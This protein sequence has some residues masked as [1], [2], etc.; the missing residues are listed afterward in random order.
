[1][2]LY[3]YN[4]LSFWGYFMKSQTQTEKSQHGSVRSYTIGFLLS[5]ILTFAAY[6]PVVIHQN[7][8]HQTF[9]HE[10]L[11]PLVLFFA[12][13]QLMVQLIFFLHLAGSGS[14]ARWNL[15]VFISTVCIVLVIVIG[16]VW[17]MSHLNYNMMSGSNMNKYIQNQEGIHK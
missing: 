5:I 10:L 6:I 4:S 17:I 2:D 15:A 14:S 7:S 8:Y 16:S 9:S 1:V 3:I 13:L 12:L 11:I